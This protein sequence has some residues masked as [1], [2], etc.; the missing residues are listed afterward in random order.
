MLQ[1][2]Y[3]HLL[4][5]KHGED[6]DVTACE[7][8]RAMIE[9]FKVRY[10]LVNKRCFGEMRDADFE[11]AKEFKWKDLHPDFSDWSSEK[12]EDLV[13]QGRLY[14]CDETGLQYQQ[15]SYTSICRN[16]GWVHE[17][18]R[19]TAVVRAR[20][21]AESCRTRADPSNWLIN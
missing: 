13:K 6:S 15:Q 17:L 19:R 14:N 9:R 16:M 11:A 7:V 3:Q 2:K 18:R 1:V 8:T 12:W 10:N 20:P 5:M 21:R 4:N